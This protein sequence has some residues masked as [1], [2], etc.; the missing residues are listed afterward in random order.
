MWTQ[1]HFF[2]APLARTN[3]A[4]TMAYN[5]SRGY[6]PSSLSIRLPLSTS[7]GD[8]LIAATGPLPMTIGR[9]SRFLDTSYA[10]DEWDICL[11]PARR[12]SLAHTRLTE[13]S[14]RQVPRANATVP[15][16]RECEGLPT[17]SALHM[18][19]AAPGDRSDTCRF[20]KGTDIL[21]T[22]L[23]APGSTVGHAPAE[24]VTARSLPVAPSRAGATSAEPEKHLQRPPT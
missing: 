6:F 23:G 18:A 3:E 13:E 20:G 4:T 16:Q 5:A 1:C 15:V 21:P 22:R 19:V 14:R 12:G 2:P 24:P 7:R 8:R 17:S 10:T 9:A 11:C